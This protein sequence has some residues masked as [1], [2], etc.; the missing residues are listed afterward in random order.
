M[1][2]CQG[3]EVPISSNGR[4]E[5]HRK[6][7]AVPSGVKDVGKQVGDALKTV[8]LFSR[9]SDDERTKIGSAL[10]EKQFKDTQN[11]ITQG[12]IGDDFFILTSG[13]A[14]V[15]RE[16]GDKETIVAELGEGDYFGESALL[17][18]DRRGAT[19]RAKGDCACFVLAREAFQKMFG[20][21]R[22]NV[23][24]AKRN[25]VLAEPMMKE[26]EE[27]KRDRNYEKSSEEE[28]WIKSAISQNV[29][30]ANLDS[31]QMS[32][33]VSAMYKL[34]VSQ[35]EAI[36]TQGEKGDNFYLVQ[37][38][39]FD[40]FVQKNDQREKVNHAGPGTSF[41][42]LALLYNAPRAAS[43]ISLCDS[44]V[45]ALDRYTFR[46]NL[47]TVSKQ[48]LSEYE[49]FLKEVPILSSLIRGERL[50]VAE[51]LE[52]HFFKD[53]Q[54]IVSE[55]EL[56]DTFYIIKKGQVVI[57][58]KDI[59]QVNKFQKGDFFGERALIKNEPRAATC[60]AL[61]DVECLSLN[62][63]AFTLLLG[64]L[65]E[66]LDS[67]SY[68]GRPGD[69]PVSP[70]SPSVAEH[71]TQFGKIKREDLELVGVL[72]RG[73]FGLVQLMKHK[74][75]GVTYALKQISKSQVVQLGQQEHVLSEKNVMIQFEHPFLIKLHATY[76]DK[77]Y[78]Y[79]LLEVCLGGEL[80]TLL[81]QHTIFKEE[82]A[83]FY[84]ASVVLCFEYMHERNI[85]YRD[86]KPENLL[87]DKDGY[88]KIVDFGFAKQVI[89]RTY[90]LCGT[91]D[92][93]APEVIIGQGHG[94]GVDWW[95][96]GVLIFEMLASFPPFYDDDPMKT[97]A[98]IMHA[99]IEFPK[100]FSP[101]AIDLISGLLHP[102]VTKRLGVLKGGAKRIKNHAWFSGFDWDA[103]YDRKLKAPFLPQI[104]N[105]EDMSNFAE[106][107]AED[108]QFDFPPYQDDGSGWENAF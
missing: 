22:F 76:R 94:K 45:W 70:R 47:M 73:S 40:I 82:T 98:K 102:K 43:V 58:K 89:D 7:D 13:A 77:D 85:V 50:Q 80:F 92:Y 107:E 78:L 12:D 30:F 101:E 27:V 75:T 99:A 32:K 15:I 105:S 74:K 64:P 57:T 100:H 52:E 6:I 33:V 79:F 25:A 62:R 61:G 9:L 38:G 8:P 21:E 35:G 66:I 28:I 93:L 91:P 10:V 24:F 104:Q 103:L 48:K 37:E 41:G 65:H 36:I 95:T 49:S 31:E 88:L 69:A 19:I 39:E 20:K 44:K 81:R 68:E 108:E 90:T 71:S 72:G 59:G 60:T 26:D 42:E 56:G 18:G 3:K 14:F 55:G 46:N 17:S 16:D 34:N 106:P 51:A 96:L 1:G 97:Y 4:P 23:R 29:L 53:G 67:L 84:A 2:I 63:M 87:L 54:V 86:L 11:I 5:V 83:K